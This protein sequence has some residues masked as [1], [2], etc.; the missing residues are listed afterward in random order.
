MAVRLTRY[1]CERNLLPQVCT[2]C[3]APAEGGARLMLL[4]PAWNLTFGLLLW[5]CPPVVPSLAN[6]VRARRSFIVP[7]CEVHRADW[8]WR[9]RLTTRLYCYCVIPAYVLAVMGILVLSV[10]DMD[11]EVL[12]IDIAGS[13]SLIYMAIAWAWLVTMLLVLRHTVRVSRIMPRWIELWGVRADFVRALIADRVRTR[14]S[15]P[16]RL[17]SY[18]DVRDDYD[19][20][21]ARL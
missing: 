16:D 8:Q 21:S 14:E 4:T 1:E 18:G 20:E 15:D 6:F 19:D 3:G 10:T 5:L 11:R 13:I 2:R 7:M 17:G 9:D 12:P